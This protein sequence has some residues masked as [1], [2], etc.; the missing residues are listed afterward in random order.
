MSIIGTVD[1]LWRYP[2]KSL[3]GEE[4]TEAFVGFAGL[5]GD[6]VFAFKSSAKAK[7]FP[8]L[9]ARDHSAIIGWRAQFRYPE[10]A[11]QPIN[12]TE[13]QTG[14]TGLTPLYAK[15]AEMSV[16]V[17][18]PSGATFAI[19]DPTLLDQLRGGPDETAELTLLYSERALTDCRP[20]SLFSLQTVAQIGAEI[21]E[22]LDKRRFRAN[23]YA[24]FTT[25][26]GFAED[27]LVG[28]SLR[29]G[30]KTVITIMGRD[31]RCVM[32][33]LDPDTGATNAQVLR[34]VAQAH[35]G[36]AGV[37]CVVL[38]EGMI[39]KGDPIELLD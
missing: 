20:V 19:D 8:Y 6:R 11:A 18:L 10:L 25:L 3:R 30:A 7:R 4:L 16:D 21:G 1:S 13:A 15:P 26:G 24:N 9:T 23:I 22:P 36:K 14:G 34:T 29:I 33:T 31:A 27:T 2:V 37:Y 12:L 17:V 39:N 38:V 28:R 35:E 5:Y 32:I